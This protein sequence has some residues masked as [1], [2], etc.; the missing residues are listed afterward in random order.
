MNVKV[1][2][3][4]VNLPKRGG[5]V[6]WFASEPWSVALLLFVRETSPAKEIDVRR[7]SPPFAES[8]IVTIK[9][10][11]LN[12]VGVLFDNPAAKNINDLG[13]AIND[14]LMVRYQW[15]PTNSLIK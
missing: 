9:P 2:N 14:H 6:N 3:R 5:I 12:N 13:V 15:W 11:V 1:I 8:Y 7:Y 4:F 10:R